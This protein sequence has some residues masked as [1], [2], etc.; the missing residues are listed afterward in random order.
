MLWL[1]RKEEEEGGTM[2]HDRSPKDI[3][4]RLLCEGTEDI[5]NRHELLA[6][7]LSVPSPGRSHVDGGSS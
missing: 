4:N 7:V 5:R 1:S 6:A 2:T 3:V